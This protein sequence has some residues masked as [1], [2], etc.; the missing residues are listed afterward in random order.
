MDVALKRLAGLECTR[1]VRGLL[2]CQ[3]VDENRMCNFVMVAAKITLNNR[4]PSRTGPPVRA[5]RAR[6]D[7]KIFT[8]GWESV[9]GKVPSQGRF[10]GD[11]RIP[12]DES[13]WVTTMPIPA[14][15]VTAKT[16]GSR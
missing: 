10:V 6:E 12:G 4:C 11:K 7:V 16:T 1:H 13:V 9:G 2:W 14:L 5:S 8:I 3:N 15:F